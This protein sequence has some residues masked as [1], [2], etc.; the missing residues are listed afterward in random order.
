MNK[1]AIVRVRDVMRGNFCLVDGL[2]TVDQAL[3][4]LRDEKARVL[5]IQKRDEDDEYGLVDLADIA[6]KVLSHNRSPERV[7][8]YEIMRK[9]AL[10]VRPEMQVKYCARL[11]DR[12]NLRAA[13]VTESAGEVAGIVSYDDLVMGGLV[14]FRDEK[15][16]E[17]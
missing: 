14:D 5:V 16:D 10:N 13:L 7:N 11:L 3:R 8:V 12:F 17:P 4:R 15:S 9:P 1:P 6:R 2:I